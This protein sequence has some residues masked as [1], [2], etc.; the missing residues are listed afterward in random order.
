VSGKVTHDTATKPAAKTP[1]QQDYNAALENHQSVQSEH[2]ELHRHRERHVHELAVHQE[3]RHDVASRRHELLGGAAL[4]GPHAE[5][6]RLK[7][8]IAN[9]DAKMADGRER[10]AA[11]DARIAV[12]SVYLAET[13]SALSRVQGRLRHEA[14]ARIFALIDRAFR[15]AEQ[16]WEL[17]SLEARKLEQMGDH[18]ANMLLDAAPQEIINPGF[19][20]ADCSQTQPWRIRLPSLEALAEERD[21]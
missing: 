1:Q 8:E 11:I 7:L 19:T 9:L 2:Q 14:A 15:D 12:T 17:A 13:G 18:T 10:L 21:L 5:A 16:A 4:A 6:D 20:R 3:R